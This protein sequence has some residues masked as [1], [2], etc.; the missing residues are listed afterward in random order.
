MAV[1]DK[2][3]T[4]P[5]QLMSSVSRTA[6]AGENIASMKDWAT[7]MQ[8]NGE[9]RNKEVALAM[10]DS[11]GAMAVDLRRDDAGEEL[12]VRLGSDGFRRGSVWGSERRSLGR[13][14]RGA[15]GNGDGEVARTRR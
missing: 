5:R 11:P 6:S 12:V 14:R 8:P 9:K 2:A 13:R 7:M 3:K 10:K 1:Q 4:L 15:L